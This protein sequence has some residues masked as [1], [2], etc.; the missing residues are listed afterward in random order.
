VT[1]DPRR[2]VGQIERY[3]SAIAGA[4]LAAWAAERRS[5]ESWPLAALSAVM[6]YRAASG[7]CPMYAAA[8]VST[9]G[10]T[11]TRR[12][13]SGRRG[14]NVEAGIAVARHVEELYTFWRRLENLPQVMQHLV[15]V[16]QIDTRRSRWRARGPLGTTVEWEAEIINEVPNKVIGWRSLEGS[17]VVTAGSVN[18]EELPGRATGVRVKLQYDPPA[19]KLGA[20]VAWLFGA[21][22]T[23]QIREDLRRFKDMMEG[24][25]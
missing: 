2:N 10:E 5:R 19:G 6:W 17:T 1:A 9:A 20:W 12:A 24:G 23:V 18:F 21:E 3:A 14:V 7:R 13:L 22:P 11:S 15:S 25:R 16:E 8:G 4:A